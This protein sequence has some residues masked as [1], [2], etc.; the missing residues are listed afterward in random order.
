MDLFHSVLEFFSQLQPIHYMLLVLLAY[1]IEN[2]FPPL[3]GDTM[4]VFTAYVFGLY[5]GRNEFIWLYV[6]SIAG[7]VLGFMMMVFLGHHFGRQFFVEKNFKFANS[8]FMTKAEKY[9]DHYGVL[10]VL[11]NRIFFGMRPVIGLVSGMSKMRW[12][13]TLIL[14]TVSSLV[15]NAAFIFLGYVL[16][17]NW[18]LIESILKKYSIFTIVALIALVVFTVIRIRKHEPKQ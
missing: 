9:M 12:Y 11:G 10:M 3:P 14:V 4:L 7:A 1:F 17:E 18:E 16:G 2:V 13:N 6:F 8:D 15:F 5:F